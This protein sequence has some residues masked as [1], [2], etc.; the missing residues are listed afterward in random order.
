MRYPGVLFLLTLTACPLPDAVTSPE[1]HMDFARDTF[2]NAPFPSDDLLHEGRLDLSGFPNREGVSLVEQSRTVLQRDTHGFS[3]M[4]GIFFSLSGAPAD[5]TLTAGTLSSN[6]L[7]RIIDLAT[8][9]QVPLR[10][11]FASDG[12]P[13]G[14]ERQ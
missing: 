3:T 10:L 1:V 14:Q 7:A 4:G 6:G 12:G 2:Y 9:Q 5:E 8:G 13:F 11:W